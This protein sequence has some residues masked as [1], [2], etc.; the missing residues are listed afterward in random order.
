MRPQAELNITSL[1]NEW[2]LRRSLKSWCMP[3]IHYDLMK[4]ANHTYFWDQN[5]IW[6]IKLYNDYCRV[7]LFRGRKN[8]RVTNSIRVFYS[9]A[10]LHVPQT[11]SWK[12]VPA[13]ARECAC[14]MDWV[15]AVLCDK[16]VSK[17][18]LFLHLDLICLSIAREVKWWIVTNTSVTQIP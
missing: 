10:L 7:V 8:A 9:R 15:N 17:L 2:D 5:S 12:R 4:Q 1:F 3:F 6:V 13:T 18:T 11:A 14:E 16:I